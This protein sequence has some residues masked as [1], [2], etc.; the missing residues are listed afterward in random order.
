VQVR[1]DASDPEGITPGTDVDTIETAQAVERTATPDQKDLIIG[2]NY[3]GHAFGHREAKA[4]FESLGD[5]QVYRMDPLF[6]Y[7]FV[8]RR[9]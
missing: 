1:A 3:Y 8:K 4:W 9:A 7:G 6:L 5:A 2:T